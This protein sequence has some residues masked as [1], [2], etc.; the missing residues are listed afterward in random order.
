[1]SAPRLDAFASSPV[2]PALDE[3][4]RD[5][6][7]VDAVLR[8][9]VWPDG[10]RTPFLYI[11][12][13]PLNVRIGGSSYLSASDL[14]YRYRTSD[15]TDLPEEVLPSLELAA[16]DLVARGRSRDARLASGD[17]RIRIL[18]PD[19][20]VDPWR[21]GVVVEVLLPGY[22]L[23][24]GVALV[25]VRVGLLLGSED[26]TYVLTRSPTGWDIIVRQWRGHP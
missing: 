18:G 16:A 23:D 14:L 21:E 2:V 1:M 12:G 15:W 4:T 6:Q 24:C 3:P 20:Q 9:I 11:H 10:G 22:G 13:R 7:V 5:Q 17:P 8:D 19:D 26:F 25:F